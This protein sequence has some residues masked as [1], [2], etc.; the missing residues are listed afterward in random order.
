MN[1]IM[2]SLLD[3]WQENA[4]VTEKDY[5]GNDG[6]LY[7]GKCHTPKQQRLDTGTYQQIQKINPDFPRIVYRMCDCQV[8]AEEKRQQALHVAEIEKMR[9][10]CF[11]EKRLQTWRFCNDRG[12]G[13][14]SAMQKVKRYAEEFSYALESNIGL[15]I[16]GSI[17]TGKS[18]LAACIGNSVVEQGYSCLMTSFFRI[19]D[20]AW[21]AED[22]EA[23][24]DSFS[25]YDLLIVDDLGVERKTGYVDEI[26]AKVIQYRYNS[27]KPII[28]TTNL[29]I[30]DMT[31]E[32]VRIEEDRVYSRLFEMTKQIQ[33]KGSDLRGMLNV[34]KNKKSKE[35]F[36]F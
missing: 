14:R 29:T 5:T 34:E 18:F 6:L 25:F 31:N 33:V 10:R 8:H 16:L 1:N 19:S 13:D 17:G 15:L 2:Q 12:I 36:G 21:K 3:S 28:V 32:K 20:G 9:E 26:V 30:A 35:I 11:P 7:C 23:Y 22:K 24:F 27:G 4:A